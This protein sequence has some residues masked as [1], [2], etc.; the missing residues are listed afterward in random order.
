MKWERCPLC[1]S[2][3]CNVIRRK[4]RNGIKRRVLKC[5][6]CTFIFLEQSNK[7]LNA[8]Y[9]EKDYR[10]KFGPN[11]KKT[12]SPQE[13]F[14]TY[15]PFQK[16]IIK[17]IASIIK[18][19]MKI[20]DI[21]CST[22]HF[23]HS[24]KGLAKTRVGLELNKQAVSF[25]KRR[26]GFKVY[27]EPIERAKIKE[28]PFDL[29]TVL[30][31]LEHVPKPI[32]FL[33]NV[34]RHLKPTGYLYLELPNIEDA[35]LSI[36]KNQSYA[37]FY[38]R[39]PHVSYFSKGTLKRLVESCGFEGNIKTV[40]R[41]N[42]LNHLNWILTGEPQKSFVEGNQLPELPIDS[43]IDPRIR[44]ELDNL[45]KKTDK[46]YKKILVKFGIAENLTFLGK[47]I[48]RPLATI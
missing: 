8:Y 28:G 9:S 22:G 7:K 32:S 33:K 20:L 30:Q 26:L 35:L 10:K 14:E 3:K 17:E 23:L 18:P 19:N 46:T 44:G 31:T 27:S 21:G 41:Y 6:D 5:A 29:I 16:E 13:I 36:Y 12:S 39:E 11:I 1:R 43:Q 34:S 2:E 25:I 24:I 38:F 37:G 48:K 45:I 42:F 15:L 47:K 4:L 40:Q